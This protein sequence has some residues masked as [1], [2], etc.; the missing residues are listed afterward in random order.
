VARQLCRGEDMAEEAIAPALDRARDPLDFD[1]VD[2]SVEHTS[3]E[4]GGGS[5][6]LCRP[7][8]PTSGE[9]R[10]GPG[11]LW[12]P[13]PDLPQKEYSVSMCGSVTLN[14]RLALLRGCE[15][16]IG[17]LGEVIVPVGVD[18][19][20]LEIVGLFQRIVVAK[21]VFEIVPLA[22]M[23]RRVDELAA[24]LILRQICGRLIDIDAKIAVLFCVARTPLLVGKLDGHRALCA[25]LAGFG[26]RL[27]G[28]SHPCA[29]L[30][31]GIFRNIQIKRLPD[32][33]G[34][35][36]ALVALP[37]ELTN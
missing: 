16:D 30:K 24:S 21:Y 25:L 12:V 4:F 10:R 8:T 32:R 3:S 13:P 11:T 17:D 18:Q 14:S 27:V 37:A 1:Q 31:Q 7:R 34:E 35:R 20:R 2:A 23:H 6:R 26:N 19:N 22:L 29:K 33:D 9:V 36:F 28:D 5:G 15:R